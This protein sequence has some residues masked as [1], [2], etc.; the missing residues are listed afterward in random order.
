MPVQLPPTPF[1]HPPCAFSL[2]A[3]MLATTFW[4][5][6]LSTPAIT[7]GSARLT[8]YSTTG[9]TVAACSL[10]ICSSECS[11]SST[12]AGA[13]SRCCAATRAAFRPNCCSCPWRYRRRRCRWLPPCPCQL[14]APQ[15]AL[16]LPPSASPR[17]VTVGH[18]VWCAAPAAPL[19]GPRTA[20]G[21]EALGSSGQGL[22]GKV[23]AY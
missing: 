12:S 15:C 7:A 16:L 18:L 6:M 22:H 23:C 20:A 10:E 21:R 19:L 17:R 3:A 13:A 11:R 4:R 8:T 14:L 9:H 5:T 2:V 1:H